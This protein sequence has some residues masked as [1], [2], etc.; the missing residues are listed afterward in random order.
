M[1]EGQTPRASDHLVTVN[2]GRR[3]GAAVEAVRRLDA[4]AVEIVDVTI[5][6]PTLNDVFFTLT[7]RKAEESG[8]EE[9]E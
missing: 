5:R 4:A 3:P 8:S 7:G 6:R 9:A 1:G 2:I